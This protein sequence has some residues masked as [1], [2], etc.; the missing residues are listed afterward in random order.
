MT[1][2]IRLAVQ[3]DISRMVDIWMEGAFTAN[4]LTPTPTERGCLADSLC[5]ATRCHSESERCWVAQLDDL[6]VGWQMLHPCRSNPFFRNRH[7]E[8]STYTQRRSGVPNLGI[9]L[10]SSATAYAD[11]A[12]IDMILGFVKDTNRAS[13]H[14]M[15]RCGFRRV[16]ATIARSTQYQAEPVPL[17]PAGRAHISSA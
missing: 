16:G 8:S 4:G 6:V 15:R 11:A 17:N 10:L 1:F 2:R 13:I 5:H 3:N 7:V 9:I 14:M 12:P